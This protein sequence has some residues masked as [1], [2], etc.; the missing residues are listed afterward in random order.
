MYNLF[1]GLTDNGHKVDVL[2][3]NTYKQH[4]EIKKV[5]NW[6]I[7]KSNYTL[8]DVDI[9]VKALS[10]FFNLFTNKSY[11]I[12]R[13]DSKF[14]RNTLDQHLEKND[15]D[16]II[17][18][19][20]YATPYIDLLKHRTNALIVLRS[21][22]VE[23]KIWENLRD[24]ENKTLKK[25]YLNLLAYRLKKYEHKMLGKVDLIA[26]ISKDDITVFNKVVY[27]ARAVYLPF[28]INF[29][30]EEFK[31]YSAPEQDQLVLFH[32]GSM[33]W[34]P[35]QE[36]FKWFFEKVWITINNKYPNI[37]LY[38]AGS[39]MPDW[40][41]KMNAQNVIVTDGYIEGKVFMKNKAI[42]VV[43]SFSGSGI[44]I[45][46][47]EGM[48]KGKIILTTEN[49]AM[50]IS[51]THNKNIFISDS[52]KEWVTIIGNLI[53]DVELAKRV[54][55]EARE[56][57]RKEFDHIVAAKILIEAVKNFS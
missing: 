10:A 47:A 34:I 15:Y 57:A 41:T 46:I 3:M 8:V 20:L 17:L 54:S 19:S 33:D 11:N 13:F 30:D 21:H 55:N 9:K 18:E 1:C 12:I 50:G 23:H 32:I 52:S 49:G 27:S 35:H 5:P 2:A 16:L 51:C 40:I 36:A 43:P 38:L 26:S 44:R 45:K 6:F 24:N 42:M 28:G 53:N 37:K 56:F 7:E 4:C 39:K 25:W 14:F 29:N 48:A 31:H 22:N